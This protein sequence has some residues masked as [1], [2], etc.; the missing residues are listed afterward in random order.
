MSK[1]TPS[2]APLP[3][4]DPPSRSSS[5]PSAAARR[6]TGPSITEFLDCVQ[7]F[8]SLESVRHVIHLEGTSY[9]LAGIYLNRFMR[10]RTARKAG[11]PIEPTTVH[12][13]VAVALFFGEVRRA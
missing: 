5:A 4:P 8:I 13:I 3:P 6:P 1:P 10:S 9:V 2:A 12:R 7:R 11:I